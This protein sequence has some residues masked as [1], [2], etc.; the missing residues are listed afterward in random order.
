MA[1]VEDL[2]VFLNTD[3]FAVEA[4][5]NATTVNVIFDAPY[6]Q[7]LDIAGSNPSILV[8]AADMPG[9]AIGD[10]VVVNGTNYQIAEP[11]QPDGTGMVRIE[12][13]EVD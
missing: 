1:L 4:T 8:A 13:E 9:A 12:L 3:D 10:A 5:W 6:S 11:P 2:T 7:N